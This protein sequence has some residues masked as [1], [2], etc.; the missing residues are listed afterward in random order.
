[1]PRPPTRPP[2]LARRMSRLA[3]GRT[4]D[5]AGIAITPDGSTI[6]AAMRVPEG[7]DL[8]FRLVAIDAGSGAHT[9]LFDDRGVDY[10]NP[11]ISHDGAT[12]AYVRT[13]KSTPAGP[14]Q[15]ELW[16]SGVD[17]PAPRRVGADWDR[18]PAE[19]AFAA[20]DQALIVVADSDG[21]APVFRVP[22]DGGGVE[23]LT[24]DD[25]AYSSVRVDSATG[26]SWRCARRGSRPPTPYASPRTVR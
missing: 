2:L 25:F 8:R 7:I 16:V 3:P 12:L 4:A 11:V 21:R 19:I 6:V 26:D 14:T 24:H 20:D 18:W 17:G 23:Q 13:V 1:M 22:L 10:E 9:P 15:Q 5:T